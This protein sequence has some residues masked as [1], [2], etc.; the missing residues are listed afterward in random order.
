M[1]AKTTNDIYI[2][3]IS[4]AL[5]SAIATSIVLFDKISKKIKQLGCVERWGAIDYLIVCRTPN[6]PNTFVGFLAFENTL[7]HAEVVKNLNDM[8]FLGLRIK[9]V[10]NLVSTTISQKATNRYNFRKN[11]N[12]RVK[13]LADNERYLNELSSKKRKCDDEDENK[14]K[15]NKVD[16]K[17]TTQTEDKSTQTND[18]LNQLIHENKLLNTKMEKLERDNKSLRRREEAAKVLFSLSKD[19]KDNKK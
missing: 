13:I 2:T 5:I 7:A 8:E 6:D 17:Q 18:L 12:N 4:S 10:E 9:V 16:K 19:N 1:T 3:I 14:P 15:K 11:S